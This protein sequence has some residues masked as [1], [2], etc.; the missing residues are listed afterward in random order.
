MESN[1][2]NHLS[3]AYGKLHHNFA[4]LL[5]ERVENQQR[6]ARAQEE[7]QRLMTIIEQERAALAIHQ[8]TIARVLSQATQ[9]RALLEEVVALSGAHLDEDGTGMTETLDA[10]ENL[11]ERVHALW[12]KINAFLAQQK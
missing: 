5:K 10:S 12:Q 4:L 11:T 1:P 9:A 3:E 7:Q 8:A 6:L 2:Y